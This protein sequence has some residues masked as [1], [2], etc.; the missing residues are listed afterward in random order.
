MGGRLVLEIRNTS[1][2]AAGNLMRDRRMHMCVYIYI[3]ANKYKYT[4]LCT[5]MGGRDESEQFDLS[6]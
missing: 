2:K 6:I 4:V 5:K 3:Y 1:M